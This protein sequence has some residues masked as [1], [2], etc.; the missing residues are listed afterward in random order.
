MIK[1]IVFNFVLTFQIIYVSWLIKNIVKVLTVD[2]QQGVEMPEEHVIFEDVFD[3]FNA[4]GIWIYDSKDSPNG[5][6]SLILDGHNTVLYFDAKA[7]DLKW[8]AL[9]QPG[10][11]SVEAEEV[12]EGIVI[13]QHSTDLM[14]DVH[15]YNNLITLI[16]TCD[17]SSTEALHLALKSTTPETFFKVLHNRISD[18]IGNALL[19]TEKKIEINEGDQLSIPETQQMRLDFKTSLMGLK[20]EQI[21]VV[22]VKDGVVPEKEVEV[23][24]EQ[25]TDELEKI[26]TREREDKQ[27]DIEVEVRPTKKSKAVERAET[28]VE[29][30]AAIIS[31]PAPSVKAPAPSTARTSAPSKKKKALDSKEDDEGFIGKPTSTLPPPAT[32]KASV[33]STPQRGG[34]SRA[35][36]YKASEMVPP[37]ESFDEEDYENEEESIESVIDKEDNLMPIGADDSREAMML[38]H[39]YTSWFSKMIRSK[40]YPLTITISD[41]GSRI[42]KTSINVISGEKKTETKSSVVMSQ[43]EDITIVPEFPGCLVVPNQKTVKPNHKKPI[44]FFVTPLAKGPMNSKINIYQGNTSIAEIDTKAAVIDHQLSKMLAITGGVVGAL[45]P[46]FAF[47]VREDIFS[48][49]ENRLN[50]S[51]DI[52]VNLQVGLSSILLLG[53]LGYYLLRRKGKSSNKEYNFSL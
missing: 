34:T 48:F 20:I 10:T 41:S 39:V 51:G 31:K 5:P 2:P 30:V 11:Y 53:G 35:K 15:A 13:I 3:S 4:P 1:N 47:V 23:A 27:A 21:K 6:F 50:L 45:P 26:K 46:L 9:S 40:I 36:S 37:M 29:D 43:D 44:E 18:A 12:G 32:T 42:T 24:S 52:A 8:T 17:A 19:S 14:V 22:S 38:K 28:P 7:K 49:F 25:V 16:I 33:P